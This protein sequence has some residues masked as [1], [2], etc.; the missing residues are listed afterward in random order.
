MEK[1]QA[2]TSD[3]LGIESQIEIDA[4]IEQVQSSQVDQPANEVLET[5]VEN[6]EKFSGNVW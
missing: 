1:Y 6:R 2:F 4:L 5:Q 3:L